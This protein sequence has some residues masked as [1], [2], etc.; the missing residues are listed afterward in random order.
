M[1]TELQSAEFQIMGRHKDIAFRSID[2]IF[3][4][5]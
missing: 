1:I 4:C 5:E 3:R 2:R